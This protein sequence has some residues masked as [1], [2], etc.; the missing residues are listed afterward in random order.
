MNYEIDDEAMCQVSDEFADH[1]MLRR[2][3]ISNEFN[4][5]MNSLDKILHQMD[6]FSGK[7]DPHYFL[8]IGS[9][10]NILKEMAEYMLEDLE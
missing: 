6:M 10:K 8:A 1:Y 3:I 7:N 9:R 5:I 2:S 4:V